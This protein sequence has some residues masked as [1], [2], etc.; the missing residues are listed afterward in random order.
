MLFGR[1]LIGP[2]MS[3]TDQLPP[4]AFAVNHSLPGAPEEL[5]WARSGVQRQLARQRAW[6]LTNNDNIVHGGGGGGSSS[7]A[8]SNCVI[9]TEAHRT[10]ALV[11]LAA[12]AKNFSGKP[13]LRPLWL[14]NGRKSGRR[15]AIVCSG[16]TFRGSNSIHRF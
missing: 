5:E 8:A 14:H 4:V 9:Y 6:R 3:R 13:L 2:L 1:H 12:K 11:G 10:R 16:Y 7:L 15:N